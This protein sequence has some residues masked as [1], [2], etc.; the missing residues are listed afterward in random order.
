MGSAFL[1]HS[2]SNGQDCEFNW[3]IS[4]AL[5]TLD[6]KADF[7]SPVLIL[8]LLESLHSFESGLEKAAITGTLNI[9]SRFKVRL[10]V[11][12]NWYEVK[13]Y[14]YDTTPDRREIELYPISGY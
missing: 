14:S 10:N 7:I 1:K 11:M 4:F 5:M 13:A 6:I 9:T 12:G 2:F 8:S 3:E